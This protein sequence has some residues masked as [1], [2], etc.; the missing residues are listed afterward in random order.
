MQMKVAGGMQEKGIVIGNTYDKYGAK[1]PVVRLIM[2]GFSNALSALVAKVN[3]RTIHEVGC[4]EGY[5]VCKWSKQKIAAR[6]T[7]FSEEVISIAR[8]NARNQGLPDNIF[9]TRSIYD[10]RPEQDGADLVIC[11]EVLEHL[12]NPAMALT[13]LQRVTTNYVIV[14]VPRE[15][16]WRMLNMMRGKY[17]R[18][19]GNTPGHLQHWSSR[20]FVRDVGQYFDIVA[21]KKPLPWTMLLCRAKK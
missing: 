14:S 4:G 1:N 17:L 21:I 18:D 7:D 5:W 15:P 10:L 11:C 16:I 12:D 19:L 9:E 2:S 13:V 6:G 8:E 20:E 3:P